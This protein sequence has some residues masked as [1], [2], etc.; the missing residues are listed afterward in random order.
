MYTNSQKIVA[1]LARERDYDLVLV[2]DP[3]TVIHVRDVYDI[4]SEVVGLYNKAHA[5]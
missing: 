5:K 4:T 1:Q 3:G 2:K